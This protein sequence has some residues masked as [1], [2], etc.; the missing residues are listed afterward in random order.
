MSDIDLNKVLPEHFKSLTPFN[1]RRIGSDILLVSDLGDHVF[2]D[3]NQFADLMYGKLAENPVLEAKLLEENFIYND[4]TRFRLADDFI[5]RYSH[6]GMRTLLHI[7]VTTLNCNLKCRYC[8]TSSKAAN[9]P[10]FNMSLETAKKVVDFIFQSPN[11]R[12][13]IEFQGG[14]PLLNW[15]VIKF[16]VEYGKEK[17][18]SFNKQLNYLLVSNFLNLE[19][20]HLRFLVENEIQICTSLDGPKDIHDSNRGR[21]HDKVVEKFRMA[22]K[23][24][25]SEMP[26]YLP[27]M[28]ITVTRNSLGR[29]KD[30]ID[31]YVELG[32]E[33]IFLRYMS[34]VG[35]ASSNWNE[36]ALTPLEFLDFYRNSM[37]YILELNQ[38]GTFFSENLTMIMLFKILMKRDTG[39]MD[40]RSPCG[41][42]VGQLAYNYDGDIFTCDE[43]RMLS[44]M[45]DDS[46]RLGNAAHTEYN[47]LLT[48]SCTKA[49]CIASTIDSLPG[50]SNCAYKTYCGVCPVLNY[51]EQGDIIGRTYSNRRHIIYEGM[52]DYLFEKLKDNKIKAIFENWLD[53]ARKTGI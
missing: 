36:L 44:R 18:R 49:I 10:E 17:N 30:I 16:I 4:D 13:T 12:I 22:M 51:Y 14:E 35:E 9:K 19:E 15:D 41:A 46:F 7:V 5:D 1:Y 25:R 34:Q 28:L 20:S 37:E 29:E 45:G 40:M 47:D 3:E 2:L 26:K 42:V 33:Y 11:P 8:Q 6:L 52:F 53:R 43:G 31:H 24:Y 38:Q 50:C 39:Y 32:A 27:G 21:S 48:H 23:M